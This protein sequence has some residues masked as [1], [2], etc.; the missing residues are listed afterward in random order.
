MNALGGTYFD[1]RTS[2]AYAVEFSADTQTGSARVAGDGIERAEGLDN[3][4]ITPRLAR[5]PRTILFGDGARLLI[6]DSMQFDSVFAQRNRLESFVDRAERHALAVALALLLCLTSMVGGFLWGLPRLADRIAAHVS[7]SAATAIGEQVLRS[8]DVWAVRPSY[9]SAARRDKLTEVFTQ[10]VQSLHSPTVY[11]VEFRDAP[12]IGPNAFALPG[13]TIVVTDQLINLLDDDREFIAVIA[14]ELGHETYNHALRQMFRSSAV[15][16]AF[17]LFGSDVNAASGLVIGLPTFLLN[18]S[19]SREFEQEADDFAFATMAA[20]H[21][22]PHWFGE[23]LREL[24]AHSKGDDLPAYF[25]SHPPTT[26]RIERAEAAGRDY[27]AKH[28][29]A[30]GSEPAA[31]PR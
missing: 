2:R 1:G 12:S 18:G 8:L 10:V 6:D 19:Y 20:N 31:S 25:S 26:E 28:P 5:I 4:S 21:V 23:V 11:Y 9:L 16:V 30:T 3:L 15:A 7:G 29:S 22:P 14:H 17:A 27:D 24:Q 13:G